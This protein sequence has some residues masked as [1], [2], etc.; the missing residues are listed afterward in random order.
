MYL[1][2]D[3]GSTKTAWRF[4]DQD[5]Q[6][7]Q[8]T[9]E[10]LNPL[11]TSEQQLLTTLDSLP[12]HWR[13]GRLKGIEFYGSGCVDDEQKSKIKKALTSKFD[14]E[15]ILVESDLLGAAKAASEGEAS[16]VCILGTGSN[17]C[18]FDGTKI[19]KRVPPL[20][21]ILGDEGSGT[22]LGKA[23]LK[24][25]LRGQLP[26]DIAEEFRVSAY[27][28]IDPIQRVYSLEKPNR[29]LASIAEFMVAYLHNPQVA[30]MVQEC[31]EQLADNIEQLTSEDQFSVNFVGSIA[32]YYQNLLSKVLQQRGLRK[33]RIIQEP[34]AA[35]ATNFIK[36]IDESN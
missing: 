27:N 14:F 11:F 9:T 26:A 17:C 19:V 3:S 33:G 24:A 29:Y 8:F 36:R 20:G 21:Y 7:S 22:A 1:F 2:A 10:G 25:Y 32:F 13:D 28:T 4:I 30:K 5:K 31:F 34:V 35:L 23:F 6:I 16:V 15:Q 12:D 18:L